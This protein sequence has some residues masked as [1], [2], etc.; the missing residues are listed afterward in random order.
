MYEPHGTIHQTA[1]RDGEDAERTDT[2]DTTE[3]SGRTT[4]GS[5]GEIGG[6]DSRHG[7]VQHGKLLHQ[8][9]QQTVRTDACGVPKGR[10]WRETLI[11][12]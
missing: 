4:E 1:R 7:G 11:A 3:E 5:A 10:I 9:L 8:V 2:R 6:R 12:I